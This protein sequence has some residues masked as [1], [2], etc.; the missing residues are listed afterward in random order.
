MQDFS[1]IGG[2][3]YANK[4]FSSSFGDLGLKSECD[5]PR[6]CSP[7]VST[8][9]AAWAQHDLTKWREIRGDTVHGVFLPAINWCHFGHHPGER[10]QPIETE[11]DQ[12]LMLRKGGLSCCCP[13][14][15]RGKLSRN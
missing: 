15:G 9:A 2:E 8:E 7:F 12:K 3:I 6:A 1:R 13:Q 11:K 4:L 10:N 5:E 14:D